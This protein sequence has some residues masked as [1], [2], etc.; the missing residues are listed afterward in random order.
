MKPCMSLYHDVKLCILYFWSGSANI[1]R[2][3]A[4][5][6]LHKLMKPCISHYNDVKLRT[7]IWSGSVPCFQSYCP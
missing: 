7:Y 2:V 3:I 4:P 6:I 1:S 5:E